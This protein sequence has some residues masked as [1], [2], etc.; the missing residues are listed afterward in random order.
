[1]RGRKG[2]GRGGKDEDKDEDKDKDEEG[3]SAEEGLRAEGLSAEGLSA[4]GLSAEGLSAPSGLVEGRC[5]PLP[6]TLARRAVAILVR[7]CLCDR[8]CGSLG[9]LLARPSSVGW[10]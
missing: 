10:P 5:R 4:Q 7:L 3:L 2:R 8:L 6:R 1:M 9:M